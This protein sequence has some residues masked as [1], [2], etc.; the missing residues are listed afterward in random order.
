[1]A[2]L[3]LSGLKPIDTSGLNPV[4]D[5]PPQELDLSGLTPIDTSGLTEVMADQQE[6][7]KIDATDPWRAQAH[8]MQVPQE[9]IEAS[10]PAPKEENPFDEAAFQAGIRE[11]PWFKEYVAEYGEEPDLRH[12][13]NDPAK[14]PNYDYRAAWQ[15]GLRPERDPYDKNRYHWS[16]FSP[17]GEQLKTD[18]HP[19]LWKG[20]FAR[21]TGKS[22]EALGLETPEQANAWMAENGYDI[23][24]AGHVARKVGAGAVQGT[25]MIV[26]SPAIM[27]GMAA[28]APRR[29]YEGTL[30]FMDAMDAGT[31]IPELLKDTNGRWP[32]IIARRYA[33]ASRTGNQER[34]QA[35]RDEV[36]KKMPEAERLSQ[37]NTP[38]TFGAYKLGQWMD[39]ATQEGGFLY[40]NPELQDSFWMTDAPQA[41]GQM[42]PMLLIGT[43]TGGTGT[44]ASGMGMESTAMYEEALQEGAPLDKAYEAAFLGAGLGTSEAL[45]VMAILQKVDRRTG[46]VVRKHLLKWLA[47][48]SEEALQEFGQTIAENVIARDLVGYDPDRELVTDEAA[49]AGGAGGVAGAFWSVV[50][51][52]LTGRRGGRHVPRPQRDEETQPPP[53]GEQLR[54]DLNSP[55]TVEQ[56]KK[57]DDVAAALPPGYTV[58]MS[59]DG[60]AVLVSP[61][62]LPMAEP[63]LDVPDQWVEAANADNA[64]RIERQDQEFAAAVAERDAENASIRDDLAAQ[65][66]AETQIL[67][68]TTGIPEPG[69]RATVTLPDGNLTSGEVVDI[70]E[71]GDAIGV[72]LRG[73]DGTTF[74]VYTDEA[75]IGPEVLPEEQNA[76]V[77]PG[78]ASPVEPA[79]QSPAGLDQGLGSP[80]TPLNMEGLKPVETQAEKSTTKPEEREVARSEVEPNPSPAQIDAGNY[81]K[82]HIKVQGLNVTIE[83]PKGSTR[84]GMD[85]DGAPWSVTMPKDYGYIRGTEGRDGD[86]LDV[87][88]GDDTN[89]SLVYVVDQLDPDTGQFDEHKVFVG[90]VMPF[91]VRKTYREAFSDGRAD[92]RFGGMT[93]MTMDEFKQLLAGKEGVL[94]RPLSWKRG[95]DDTTR[96]E[97]LGGEVARGPEPGQVREREG[98]TEPP[99]AGGVLQTPGRQEGRAQVRK[100]GKKVKRRGPPKDLLTFLADRGGIIDRDG[101]LRARDLDKWHHERSFRRKLIRK[102]VESAAQA[103][104]AGG[105]ATGNPNFDYEYEQALEAAIDNGYF[106]ELAGRDVRQMDARQI[107]LDAIDAGPRFQESDRAEIEAKET[108]RQ[109]EEAQQRRSD[110]ESRIDATGIAISDAGRQEAAERAAA[111]PDEDVADIVDEIAEREAVQWVEENLQDISESDIMDI[112]WEFDDAQAQ[113]QGQEADGGVVQE[114]EPPAEPVSAAEGGSEAARE[115]PRE[116]RP[117]RGG[118]DLEDIPKFLDRRGEAQKKKAEPEKP[119]FLDKE[120]GEVIGADE[121]VK[122]RDAERDK[123]E[124]QAR[125][126]GRITPKVPQK[127]ADTGLFQERETPLEAAVRK[128]ERSQKEDNLTPVKVSS[129]IQDGTVWGVTYR[130]QEY[131]IQRN[132]GSGG[133]AIN[134]GWYA[135]PAGTDPV[136]YGRYLGDTRKE[137]IE[138]IARNEMDSFDATER[139]RMLTGG[140]T[141]EN[142]E[143]VGVALLG[144]VNPERFRYTEGFASR[145]PVV[146][147]LLR[148]ELDRLG[149][150]D[151]KVSIERLRKG[152]AGKFTMT[153]DG[154]G[155]IVVSSL[156]R[157]APRSLRHEALH[158]FRA[159]GLI[160]DKEWSALERK[161]K[162]EGWLDKTW[163]MQPRSVREQ[164]A[165]FP[166][167]VQMEEAVAEAFA[168]GKHSPRSIAG[169]VFERISRFFEAMGNALRGS[170]FVTAAGIME[171]IETGEVGRR[172]RTI[173]RTNTS[174]FKRWFKNSKVV[175]ANGNPL[176]VY[177][178]T[179]AINHVRRASEPRVNDFQF[180]GRLAHF[181]TRKAANDRLNN[182]RRSEGWNVAKK[183]IEG[184][185]ILPVYL[186]IQNPLRIV[187]RG[188]SGD[189]DDLISAIKKAGIEVGPRVR[190]RGEVIDLLGANGYD[191]LV[192]TNAVEDKGSESWVVL[193]PEQVKSAFNRGTWDSEDIR[194]SYSIEDDLYADGDPAGIER[195]AKR[196]KRKKRKQPEG[197]ENPDM[198]GLESARNPDY[199]RG[200][201]QRQRDMEAAQGEG[202]VYE[203]RDQGD[204]GGDPLARIPDSAAR[205]YPERPAGPKP[206]QNRLGGS[207]DY[208]D[209]TVVQWLTDK[210]LATTQRLW[211]ASKAFMTETR[212]QYQDKFINLKFIQEAIERVRGGPLDEGM[213]AYL[214]EELY[215]GR[216]GKQLD[217]FQQDTVEPLIGAIREE[218]LDIADVELYLYARHAPERNAQ[219][220]KINPEIPEG[221]SGMTDQ[222]AADIM[223]DFQGRDMEDALKRI[224]ER[225]DAINRD[226]LAILEN[227][228]LIDQRTRKRW[229]S[230]YKFYVPL[231]GFEEADDVADKDLVGARTGKGYDIRGIESQRALGRES[232][233]GDILAH[234]ISQY[235]EAVVRAEKNKVGKTFFKLVQGNPNPTLWQINEVQYTRRADPK[236]GLVKMVPDYFHKRQDNV[237]AVKVDGKVNYIEIHHAG[238][239]RAFKNL[240][241]E[242]MNWMLKALQS[243][244]RFLAAVNTNFNP[245]FV[246]SNAL[247]DIQTA[248][249]NIQEFRNKEGMDGLTKSIL[250]D[251]F[252]AIKAVKGGLKGKRDTEWQRWFHEFA[253]SGGKIAFFG[254]D[255]IEQKRAKIERMLGDVNPSRA[256]KMAIVARQIIDYIGDVNQSVE[257]AVRLS[258]YVNLRRRGVSR[259]RAASVARNLTVNFNRK[260]EHS[261]AMGSLYLFFNATVQ[262]NVRLMQAL[263]RSPRV[264]KVA[265]GVVV[266]SM[267]LELANAFLLSPVDDDDEEQKVYDKI[268]PWTKEHNFI[269]MN[270]WADGEDDAIALKFPYPYGYNVLAVMGQKLGEVMRGARGAWEASADILV[271]TLDAFN[272]LGGAPSLLQWIIPTIGKPWAQLSLNENF[273][274]APIKP[275]PNTWDISPPPDSQLYW[276]RASSASKLIAEEMNEATGGSKVRPGLIDISPET[277]DHVV[278]F[279]GGGATAF[280]KRAGEYGYNLAAGN[281]V[282]WR[283]VPFVRRVVE[284]RN[285]WSDRQRYREISQA[286]DYA[287]DELKMFRKEK[288][289]KGEAD[290]KRARGRDLRIRHAVDAAEKQLRRLRKMKRQTE[291]SDTFSDKEKE[292]RLEN[293]DDRMTGIVRR[294][295]KRYNELEKRQ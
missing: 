242:D 70:L 212:R 144:R 158:A 209:P 128:K 57:R 107:L 244:N 246:I 89:S 96:G 53:R 167:D 45:P 182:T 198:P 118:Q 78:P 224:A 267:M 55:M 77:A 120:I 138:R 221:G 24:P 15:A 23:S 206:K 150:S 261:A 29:A 116:D 10:R 127:E 131:H 214:S 165:E 108:A 195:T 60:S 263:Y 235:E 154:V 3:D 105:P 238:L 94:K 236:T 51:S 225:V 34:M 181:G 75:D 260:G 180:F 133:D 37:E 262:G 186:S 72:T 6:P 282:K 137:A 203:E 82:G 151:V 222:E 73:D 14:G 176:R 85:G 59:Q 71:D 115:Q 66:Q 32:S 147:D 63:T 285:Q 280:M 217:D 163:G 278:E 149:L 139:E 248:L 121:R 19:T 35:L 84:S 188:Y 243:V 1:M 233:A 291:A 172:A 170:G 93:R 153:E 292:R 234:T 40:G 54:E 160:S 87:Y 266:G 187:D 184:E 67:A 102:P 185:R 132:E 25:S 145:E 240:G 194:I 74:D 114:A 20:K 44:F 39:T 258:T 125:R 220:A 281:E 256:R 283:D 253:G 48:G 272:P 16:D 216:T 11:T 99:Q 210:N 49:R 264:R 83:N 90:F 204:L 239:A 65:G 98:G 177:H 88:V 169:R 136:L 254:L 268:T 47:N 26:K 13:S 28:D 241:A 64:S 134:G 251:Y 95:R 76:D 21:A 126:A 140:V 252:N 113:D 196:R 58:R 175:D 33:A 79:A 219:I 130:G 8:P 205:E 228:G 31:P 36:A 286:A 109:E 106:P 91:L 146:L 135:A 171:R 276:S 56:I 218:G 259:A 250:K 279:F 27:A 22:P 213:D 101:E 110:I 148:Q 9:V 227:G 61:D 231:R 289:A 294:V 275:E 81:K 284:G 290:L 215:H 103:D 190:T 50:A 191:G 202:D 141:R 249:V 156:A 69:Q 41:I 162:K 155:Q 80:G 157:N 92:E 189:V 5:N 174:A 17:G 270:P 52:I 211:G 255:T 68:E 142:R 179:N 159:M 124:L 178:G 143:E 97:Q 119:V 199:E 269:L 197:P 192:Y 43:V 226:R 229:D 122:P 293:I 86:H 173:S 287:E 271:A 18:S 223:A 38:E 2:P 152:Q 295:I 4:S 111:R 12:P 288:N 207:W 230:T 265:A 164:Y 200:R 104:M 100:R 201:R 42:V 208:S 30:A 117:A 62:G 274:G 193:R 257:N 232:R 46:G 129:T 112:P 245:E 273:M 161:A 168:Y 7:A 247:R 123:A 277:I 183:D 237:F 166:E